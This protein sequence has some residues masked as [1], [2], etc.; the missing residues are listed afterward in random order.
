MHVLV[1]L[2]LIHFAI[3]QKLTQRCKATLLQKENSI[4]LNKMITLC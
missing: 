2:E 1:Y 3:Q 4:M